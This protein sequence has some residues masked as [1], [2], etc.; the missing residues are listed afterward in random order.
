MCGHG[1][2]FRDRRL[3]RTV[4]DDVE[5]RGEA[6]ASGVFI[7][8]RPRTCHPSSVYTSYPEFSKDYGLNNTDVLADTH[9]VGIYDILRDKSIIR[10]VNQAFYDKV[11][12]HEWLSLFSSRPSPRNTSSTSKPIS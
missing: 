11:Y 9:S 12:N 5:G 10:N 7:H 1:A 2:G 4:P 8:N 3:E 6:E